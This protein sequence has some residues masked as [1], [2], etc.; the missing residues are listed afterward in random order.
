VCVVYFAAG[1]Q[2][3]LETPVAHICAITPFTLQGAA[4]VLKY[5]ISSLSGVETL[6][7]YAIIK[8]MNAPRCLSLLGC[9]STQPAWVLYNPLCHGTATDER[10]FLAR[11]REE[12]CTGQIADEQEFC[13]FEGDSL[14][15]T[16]CNDHFQLVT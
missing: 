7:F 13:S 9:M 6:Y 5:E 3:F 10:N 2:A 16:R 12:R 14:K 8:K 11:E 1:A 15:L 4:L